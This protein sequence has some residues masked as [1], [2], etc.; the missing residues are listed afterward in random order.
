[1]PVEVLGAPG[2]VRTVPLALPAGPPARALWLQ[3]HGLSSGRE[4]SLQVNDGPWLPIDDAIAQ[5]AEP[6]RTFGGVGGG[7]ATV[8][9]ALPLAAGALRAGPNVLRFRWNGDDG[10]AVG[11]RVLRLNALDEGGQRLLPEESFYE[12]QPGGWAPPRPAPADLAAGRRL[13]SAAP[14]VD[15]ATRRPLRATCADCH[16]ADGRDLKYFGYSNLAIV[17]MAKRF[18]LSA[19]EGEQIASHVRALPIES[20]G[21]PW[22]PPYQ[23]GPG[24]DARPLAEWAAGAGIDAVLDEDRGI[25]PHLFPRGISADAIATSGSI[26]LREIPIAFQLPDWNRWLPLEHPLDAWGGE[27][28]ASAVARTYADPE[29]GLRG[30]LVARGAAA[31][32]DEAFRQR[33][34]A[35]GPQEIEFSLAHRPRPATKES[36]RRLYA[37]RQWRLVKLWELMQEFGLEGLGPEIHGPRAQPRSWFPRW[38]FLAEQAPFAARVPNDARG[39]GG[40]AITNV[41]LTNAWY[42]LAAILQGGNRITERH[43]PVPW[44]QVFGL[45][46]DLRR[47]TKTDEPY[48][49][50]R[51]L[52]RATQEADNDRPPGPAGW[53]LELARPFFLT[54]ADWERENWDAPR[55]RALRSRMIAAY[56]ETWLAKNRS[57]PRE[58]WPLCPPTAKGCGFYVPGPDHVPTPRPGREAPDQVMNMIRAFRGFDVDCALL[59]DVAAWGASMWPRGDWAALR[60]ACD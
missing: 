33:L 23:P 52:V 20:P 17:E 42:E 1:M 60:A 22:N 14:L 29:A 6:E 38:P 37:L 46:G 58:A 13:W 4:A 10:I 45:V 5:V 55:D 24:L 8:R 30:A 12:E 59:N 39:I 43:A 50:F 44:V 9:L 2:T 26:P 48:R 49:F 51:L 11:F 56:L 27:F 19:A 32:L 57:L 36:A 16:T 54:L 3:V 31:A 35:W 7:F 28:A 41:Y 15:P 53:N 21:R 40:R 25:V 47:L 18:G 34:D